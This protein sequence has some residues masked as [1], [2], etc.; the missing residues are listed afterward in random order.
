VTTCVCARRERVQNASVCPVPNVA[1]A[2]TYAQTDGMRVRLGVRLGGCGPCAP[3]RAYAR[4]TGAP[5][6]RVFRAP[7]VRLQPPTRRARIRVR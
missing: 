2:Y 4:R 3:M 6:A 1:R 7:L 5:L